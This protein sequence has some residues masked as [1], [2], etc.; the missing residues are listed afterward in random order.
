MF[1]DKSRTLVLRAARLALLALASFTAACTGASEA[2]E[3]R[4]V[5]SGRRGVF[6]EQLDV[7]VFQKGNLH[8]HSTESDGDHSPEEVYAWYRDHGYNF[9]GLSDHNKFTDPNRYRALVERPGFVLIPAEEITMKGGGRLVHVNAL[10][11]RSR[12]PAGKFDTVDEALRHGVGQTLAQG[13]VALVNHPNFKWAFSSEALPSAQ[14]AKLLEI[15]SG[16]PTSF[17][18]GN[19][20]HPSVESMWDAALTAGYDFAGVAVD[21]MHTLDTPP[22]T[23][24]AGPGRG[25]VEVFAQHAT[26]PEICNALR[27]GWLIASSGVRLV[28]LTVRGDVIS[29]VAAAPGG[30]VDFIGDNGTLLARQGVNPSGQPNGYRLRGG[31]R[32]VRAKVTAPGGARAWTQAYRVSY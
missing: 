4:F 24:K 6:L 23:E 8:T 2:S 27:R 31:E 10:C 13:G 3:P 7:S 18:D 11:E 30:V 29:L 5:P 14:G 16:Y 19:A 21:D 17:P 12:I 15:W 22:G 1:L 26:E 20:H 32:Y 9:L 28:R 25:W